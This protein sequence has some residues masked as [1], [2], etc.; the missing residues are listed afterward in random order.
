MFPSHDPGRKCTM[1]RHRYFAKK[2]KTPAILTFDVLR[3]KYGNILYEIDRIVQH[4][5]KHLD[6]DN[7]VQLESYTKQLILQAKLLQDSVN[8][9]EKSDEFSVGTPQSVVNDGKKVLKIVFDV[10]NRELTEKQAELTMKEIHNAMKQEDK[11][12]G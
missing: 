3:Q 8:I 4:N 11:R 12:N 6:L 2:Y 9:F 5:Q 1:P 10:L 7:P